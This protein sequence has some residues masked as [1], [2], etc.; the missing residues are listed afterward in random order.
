VPSLPSLPDL[1]DALMLKPR[2]VCG[3]TLI[4]ASPA[5]D[6]DIAIKRP[7]GKP[8]DLTTYTIQPVQPTLCW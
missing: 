4:P 1:A 7:A 5:V 8:K 3:T 2:I 6:P